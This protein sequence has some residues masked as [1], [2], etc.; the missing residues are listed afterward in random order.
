MSKVSIKKKVVQGFLG[1]QLDAGVSTT[2]WERW[3]PTV[4]LAQHDDVQVDRL[5]LL[6]DVRYTLLAHRVRDDFLQLSP[7]TDVQ[8]VEM[9]FANPW[10]FGEV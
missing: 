5:E 9:N 2:R 7:S 10:D 1:T 8:L 6:H 4:S 3:R